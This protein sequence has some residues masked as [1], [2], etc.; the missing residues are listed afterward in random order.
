MIFSRFV[1]SIAF[2]FAVLLSNYSFAQNSP[3]VIVY[4]NQTV[5]LP[6]PHWA[7]DSNP[8][9][10]QQLHTQ[11]YSVTYTSGTSFP[12]STY[13]ATY[14]QSSISPALMQQPFQPYSTNQPSVY[15]DATGAL[16]SK[17]IGYIGPGDMRTHLWE[18]HSSDLQANGI[19]KAVL[20][21]MPMASVQKWHNYFHGTEAAP[22]G[23]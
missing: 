8:H 20:T 2:S 7:F 23:P 22:H 12:V 18:D 10:S 15:T 5:S 16:H 6:A 14:F 13:G 19:S 9:A 11:Q 4:G 1:K 17:D 3:E 21:S